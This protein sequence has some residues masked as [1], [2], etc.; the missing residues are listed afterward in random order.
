MVP[1]GARQTSSGSA[2]APPSGTSRSHRRTA[3]GAVGH[4]RECCCE[5]NRVSCENPLQWRSWRVVARAQ[6]RNRAGRNSMRESRRWRKHVTTATLNVDVEPLVNTE[7]G[8]APLTRV[9]VVE[10]SAP[11]R[12]ADNEGGVT[13]TRLGVR[14]GVLIVSVHNG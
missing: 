3:Q 14:K 2:D 9:S 8:R 6:F 12:R 4:Q 7:A 11:P 5:R 13:E 10:V 1:S